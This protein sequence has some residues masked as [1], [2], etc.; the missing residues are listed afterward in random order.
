MFQY[1]Q[2]QSSHSPDRKIDMNQLTT[3][4][5]T[6]NAY[7]YP[8]VSP[9][10]KRLMSAMPTADF[11]FLR[12][13]QMTSCSSAMTIVWCRETRA[14]SRTPILAWTIFLSFQPSNKMYDNQ[15]FRLLRRCKIQYSEQ[16]FMN[17]ARWQLF[18]TQTQAIPEKT[19]GQY[20][21]IQYIWFYTLAV[22]VCLCYV[23]M[24]RM[25]FAQRNSPLYEL[26][27]YMGSIWGRLDTV[28]MCE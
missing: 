28:A 13:I 2:I 3:Y 7:S 26:V 14:C 20:I 18:C 27:L 21:F 10:A 9:V 23:Y 1:I 15:F 6:K 8:F 22:L 4:W 24:L 17:S 5:I 11:F 19:L 25:N 12:S 16:D